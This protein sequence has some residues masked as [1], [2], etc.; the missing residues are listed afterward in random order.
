MCHQSQS[1]QRRNDTRT[2]RSVSFALVDIRLFTRLRALT[3][4]GIELQ[5]LY[6]F[7]E[8]TRRLSLTSLTIQL[9][10]N[11]FDLEESQVAQPR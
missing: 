6:P 2:D 3:L 5:D 4:L 9:R 1:V 8:H 11:Y 10:S 7:L